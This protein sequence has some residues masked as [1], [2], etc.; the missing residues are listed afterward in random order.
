MYTYIFY[1]ILYVYTVQKKNIAL[2][3]MYK[4]IMC[5]GVSTH[6][7][8]PA[9]CWSAPLSIVHKFRLPQ[10]FGFFRHSVLSFEHGQVYDTDTGCCRPL[11]LMYLCVCS[12]LNE[13]PQFAVHPAL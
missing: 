3:I 4:S 10:L 2:D 5:P 1:Y 13:V 7:F 6:I 8:T 9:V 12:T 11:S